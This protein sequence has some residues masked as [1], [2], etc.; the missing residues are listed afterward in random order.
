MWTFPR[1]VRTEI[2][3]ADLDILV[4]CH[5]FIVDG[6]ALLKLF[7]APL[8]LMGLE[9][10]DIGGVTSLLSLVVTG[11]HLRVVSVLLEHDFLVTNLP[12]VLYP[13]LN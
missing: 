7:V 2:S 4:V 13:V 11:H 8:L 3:F 5:V 6:A 10:G 9:P 1:T 12:V